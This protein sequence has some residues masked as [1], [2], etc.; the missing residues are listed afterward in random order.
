[1][2]RRIGASVVAGL[3]GG[4]VFGLMMQMMTAPMPD[5]GQIPVIA[6]VGQIV[7]SSTVGVGWLYHLFNSAVIGA[8]FGWLLGDRVHG[9]ASALGWGA[10][11]GFAWWII[12]GLILMPILL[13]MPAFAPLMMPP[14]RMVGIGSL[15]GHLI[16]GSI[17]GGA[18][19]WLYRGAHHRPPLHA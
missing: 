4:V 6:M 13:G 8:I 17:L 16:Y 5:G 2:P 9:Y 3:M 19:A 10:A 15:V 12:G 18:F 7:G 11:Y 14:M 1:M